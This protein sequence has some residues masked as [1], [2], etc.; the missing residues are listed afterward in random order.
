MARKDKYSDVKKENI[1]KCQAK[2]TA[3]RKKR[4]AARKKAMAS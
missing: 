3:R 1:A 4:K 2:K